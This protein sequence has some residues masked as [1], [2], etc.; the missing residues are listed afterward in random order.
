LQNKKGNTIH[1]KVAADFDLYQFYEP[2]KILVYNL[3]TNAINFTEIGNIYVEAM[4]TDDNIIISVRDEGV[5]MTHEQ[6]Q[7]LRAD[8]VVITAANVDN[9]KGHGLG[10]LIIKDLVKTMGAT[11][12]IESEKGKG[13]K[14][15]VYFPV[16]HTS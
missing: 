4:H 1:N 5:G 6:I 11:L 15:S 12:Q 3:L 14:V 9:K 8:E 16:N 2:V 7:R 10:Y 13:T